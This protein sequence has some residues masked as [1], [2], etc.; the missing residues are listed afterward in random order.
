LGRTK[1]NFFLHELQ[2]QAYFTRGSMDIS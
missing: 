1:L 2:S